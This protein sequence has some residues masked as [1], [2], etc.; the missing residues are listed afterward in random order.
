MEQ[1]LFQTRSEQTGIQTY[2]TFMDAM[3]ATRDDKT[4]WKISF[5]LCDGDRIRLIKTEDGWI[6]EN[7][8]DGNR[9]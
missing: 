5:D 3:Q 1:K 6:Y 8:M 4:I 9:F 7:V 2:K